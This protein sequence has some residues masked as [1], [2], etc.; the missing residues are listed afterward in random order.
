MP[1]AVDPKAQTTFVL[2]AERGS[3]KPTKFFLRPLT[4]RQLARVKDAGTDLSEDGARVKVNLASL[5]L[6]AATQGL[7]GWEDFHDAA[8]A[9]VPFTARNL[10]RLG[11]D[12]LTE[13]GHEVLR[14]NRLG[15]DD[16]KNSVSA[17]A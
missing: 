13:I 2:A 16:E 11:L 12:V 8:G 15:G 3:L 17:P 9:A 10:E 5:A 4:M 6:E 7:V 1:V 14:L